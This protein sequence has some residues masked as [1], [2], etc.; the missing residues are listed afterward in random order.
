MFIRRR[1]QHSFGSS[2]PAKSDWIDTKLRHMFSCKHPLRESSR[3]FS[4]LTESIRKR[5][6][7]RQSL[8]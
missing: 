5:K 3:M 6:P 7:S 1:T 8:R 4:K 2:L